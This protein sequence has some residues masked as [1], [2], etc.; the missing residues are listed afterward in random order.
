M[1]GS[2]SNLYEKCIYTFINVWMDAKLF[3]DV[4]ILAASVTYDHI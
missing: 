4:N 3:N 1:V 2:N